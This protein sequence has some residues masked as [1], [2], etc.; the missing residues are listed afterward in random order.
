LTTY[1]N[2]PEPKPTGDDPRVL[3]VLYGVITFV[4]LIAM[5]ALARR[6]VW[7]L[8]TYHPTHAVVDSTAI[9]LRVGRK[10]DSYVPRVYFTYSVDSHSYH[11]TRV[12]PADLSGKK[13]WAEQLIANYQPHA[14]VTG[15]YD[16]EQPDRSFLL[17]SVGSFGGMVAIFGVWV[18]F[19]AG[20]VW[21][22]ARKRRLTGA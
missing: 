7:P 2:D 19:A 9:E 12:T 18:A 16:P 8:F 20:L 4:V 10:G 15:Y 17:H 3:G 1:P 11:G 5:A 13:R 6:D 14:H 21:R 22:A